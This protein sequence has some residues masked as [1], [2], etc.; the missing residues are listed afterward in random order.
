MGK[1]GG[2]LAAEG[3]GSCFARA[4]TAWKLSDCDFPDGTG[5][6]ESKPPIG[7]PLVSLPEGYDK[8]CQ[9]MCPGGGKSVYFQSSPHGCAKSCFDKEGDPNDYAEYTVTR[10]FAWRNGKW[11]PSPPTV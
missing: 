5:Q 2:T 8:I 1:I 3:E 9:P 4:K 7:S 10:S 11:D 6:V